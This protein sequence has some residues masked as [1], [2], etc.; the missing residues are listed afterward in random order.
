MQG[1]TY[2]SASRI[3][4]R[5][6][7]PAM[8]HS[9]IAECI[10]ERLQ[11]FWT[12]GGALS[13]GTSGCIDS[14][15]LCSRAVGVLFV[16][17]QRGAF[18]PPP[19]APEQRSGAAGGELRST[20]HVNATSRG[21]QSY[22]AAVLTCSVGGMPGGRKALCAVAAAVHLWSVHTEGRSKTK[23]VLP[24]LTPVC[25]LRKRR[26]HGRFSGLNR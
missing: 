11:G 17:A 25:T 6:A 20:S 5:T 21:K 4:P 13:A 14:L 18:A 22:Q 19:A 7:L 23:I 9:W 15:S 3:L 12:Q 2:P 10:D 24:S 1:P 8:L 16:G 26:W